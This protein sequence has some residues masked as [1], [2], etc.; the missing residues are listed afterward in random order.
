MEEEGRGGEWKRREGGR[1]RVGKGK[2]SGT[3]G[4]KGVRER[5]RC[6]GGIWEREVRRH[7]VSC[8]F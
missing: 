1:G 6:G 4:S 7:S 2:G 3:E 8:W 5:S